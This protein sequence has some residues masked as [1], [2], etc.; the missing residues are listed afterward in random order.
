MT[1]GAVMNTPA[2]K[3]FLHKF[4]FYWKLLV[5]FIPAA[6]LEL[7]WFS[8]KI[9]RDAGKCGDSGGDAGNRWYIHAVLR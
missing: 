2:F 5:A 1:T 9:D 7:S 3:R 6:V 8:D 4:D